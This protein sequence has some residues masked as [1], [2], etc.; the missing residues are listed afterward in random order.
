[1]RVSVS[2]MTKKQSEQQI[3]RLKSEAPKAQVEIEMRGNEYILIAHCPPVSPSPSQ[4]LVD[5][6]DVD[7]YI[8]RYKQTPW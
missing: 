4:E 7:G 5:I 1:M 3:S 2:P 8:E 6:A